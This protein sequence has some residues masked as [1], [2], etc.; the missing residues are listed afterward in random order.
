MSKRKKNASVF[1][2][3]V[4]NH[5][6]TMSHVCGLFA[7]RAYNLEGIL[8]L[9]TEKNHISKMWLLINESE[10]IEQ[11]AKQVNKL[12]DVLNLIHHQG[13]SLFTRLEK[14]DGHH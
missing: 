10:R 4:R 8:C 11:V 12:H 5:P 13:S 7:R 1:E 2:L 14:F 9:P 6:G 3:E